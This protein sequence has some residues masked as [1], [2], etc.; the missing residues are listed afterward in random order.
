MK[1][2]KFFSLIERGI[3]SVTR[4]IRYISM[5]T[6][7]LMMCLITADVIGRY[8]FNKPIKGALEVDELMM[9]VA[10]F[11]ALAYCTMNRAHIIVEILL[12]RLSK[13]TQAILNSFSSICGV[14][15]IG[16]ILWQTGM[17]GWEELLSPT[18]SITMLLSIP[19]A[20]FLLLAT[21]GFILMV[22]ELIISVIHYIIEV[23][24]GQPYQLNIYQS[25][26]SG[27]GTS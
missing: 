25:T 21:V 8:V 14:V 19:I 5:A 26:G 11:L 24:T 23:K 2:G 20:P 1:L 7:F 22:L 16:I 3:H 9:V 10:V 4:G 17:R 12:F 18:G 6:L 15:I 13:R 27:Q